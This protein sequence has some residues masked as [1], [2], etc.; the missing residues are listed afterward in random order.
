MTFGIKDTL[1]DSCHSI[2]HESRVCAVVGGASVDDE[3][4]HQNNVSSPC[5]YL[6]GGRGFTMVVAV[7]ATVDATT[8]INPSAFA[9]NATIVARSGVV[10]AKRAV[11]SELDDV[12]DAP[13]VEVVVGHAALSRGRKVISHPSV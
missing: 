1:L 8:N 12:V 6:H 5:H 13:A 10:E 9:P 7:D 2:G 11:T 3:G 4:V